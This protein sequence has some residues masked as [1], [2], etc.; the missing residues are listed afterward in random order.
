M[1]KLVAEIHLGNIRHNAEL[2][3]KCTG[4]KLC[5]VVKANA[6]GHGAEE[7]TLA[8]SHIA[9]CFA[10]ALVDEGLQIRQAAC[11]KDILVFSP[12][13][14]EEDAYTLAVNGFI[15]TISD[16][17]TAKLLAR[18]CERYAL[19]CRVHLK[20][21][22]GMNRFGMNAS[23]LGKVC[24]FLQGSP[25]IFVEGIYSHLYDTTRESAEAQRKLFCQMQKVCKRYFPDV[26]AHISATYG[27]TL[28]QKFALDMVRVGLGLYGYTPTQTELSLRKG[29]TVK[30]QILCS[31]KVSFGGVGYGHATVE[32]GQTVALIRGGYADGFLRKKEN[33]TVGWSKNAN[34]LCM[35]VCLR[36]SHQKRG[37]RTLLLADA[38]ET[39]RETGTIPYEVLCA[40]TRRAEMVYDYDEKL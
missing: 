6:Y 21:N 13:I 9:D 11:G 19:P 17:W 15:A 16:L 10:V 8:L 12:P 25:W 33:G 39:A 31:R 24:R 26:C 20:V 14:T 23:M 1:Q 7:V 34:N 36:K 2:F 5:A 4:A 32:K 38:E 22:T 27:A 3:K 37:G 35:D 29:M 40:A 18:V 28:G 30:G